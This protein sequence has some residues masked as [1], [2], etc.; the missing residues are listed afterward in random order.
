MK[1]MKRTVSRS[2]MRLFLLAI[3]GLASFN[4][5]AEGRCPPGQY[6]VGDQNVGGCAPIPGASQSS[7]PKP[8]G[9]W[10]TRWGAIVED[11]SNLATGASVSMESKREAIAEATERCKRSGGVKC[12]LRIAYYNQCVAIADPTPEV[13]GRGG[14]ESMA[15][16]AETLEQA[17]ARAMSRCQQAVGGQE[18]LISYSACSR[19][20]FR[21]F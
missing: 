1:D 7:S 5:L 12:K 9:E 21:R 8:V 14:A 17:K 4:S 3:L 13:M 11:S 18:C 10:E 19:S 20:E 6:P 2:N 15:S 16:S